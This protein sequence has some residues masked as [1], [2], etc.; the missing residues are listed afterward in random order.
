[1]GIFFCFLCVVLGVDLFFL[2]VGLFFCFFCGFG[3]CCFLC[4]FW[5]HFGWCVCLVLGYGVVIFCLHDLV[6]LVFFLCGVFVWVG[7]GLFFFKGYGLCGFS[8]PIGFIVF[9]VGGVVVC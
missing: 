5:S 9:G 8:Q 3:F 6:C 7:W 2:W 1:M 4:C